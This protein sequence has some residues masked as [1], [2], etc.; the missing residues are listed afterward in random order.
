MKIKN[1]KS[2]EYMIFKRNA[3]FTLFIV[4]L[5]LKGK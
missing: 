1:N 4:Q 5:Y 2:I 3:K